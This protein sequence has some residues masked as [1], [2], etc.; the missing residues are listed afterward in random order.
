MDTTATLNPIL[1]GVA[2]GFMRA[3][4]GFVGRRLFPG[5]AS[6]LQA[7]AY[8]LFTAAELAQVGNA[9]K[10]APGTPYPRLKRTVSNDKFAA[11]NYGFE[12]PVPDE[13]RKKYAAFFDADI[14]ATRQLVDSITIGHEIRVYNKVTDASVP[15]AALAVPWNSGVSNP[16][17]DVDVA[18]EQIRLNIGLLPNIMVISQPILNVLA[19]HPK[20]VDLFKYTR[21]GVL[22]EQILAAYFGVDEVVVAKNVIATNNEGQAFTPADIWGNLVALAHVNDAQDLMVPSFG[23]T[24]YWTAF[25]S[26]VTPP[27]GGTGPGMIMGGGPDLLSITSYRDETVKSDIH[28]SE[29]YTDEKLTAAKAGFTLT[30]VLA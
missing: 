23:R 7:A 5:F 18:R 13:D 16:R 27:T 9:A 24:F 11:E 8:Y 30:S 3:R 19:L 2:N 4:D 1:T 10:R 28:R 6:A 26:E 17:Q 29:H 21:P 14:A 22:N 20:L 25:T 12:A 15:T